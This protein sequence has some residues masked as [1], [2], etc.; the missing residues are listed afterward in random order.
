MGG[1]SLHPIHLPT[2]TTLLKKDQQNSGRWVSVS[3]PAPP[4]PCLPTMLPPSL[5]HQHLSG[6]ILRQTR[7]ADTHKFKEPASFF[8]MTGH[9]APVCLGCVGWLGG[10]R[11]C[12]GPL[13]LVSHRDGLTNIG[14][15][16]EGPDVYGTPAVWHADCSLPRG[17][18]LWCCIA[19]CHEGSMRAF[20]TPAARQ[21]SAVLRDAIQVADSGP[22][23]KPGERERVKLPQCRAIQGNTHP[24]CS[25]WEGGGGRFF[26]LS[27][28]VPGLCLT[29]WQLGG[30]RPVLLWDLTPSCCGK[31]SLLQECASFEGPAPVYPVITV[32]FGMKSGYEHIGPIKRP[33]LVQVTYHT[34]PPS[35]PLCYLTLR[36]LRGKV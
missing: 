2:T 7:Q 12:C 22:E 13:S 23:G 8:Q 18:A 19:P 3:R 16:D 25:T 10:W 36:L 24:H 29:A 21:N 15:G 34:P 26:L 32:E 14:V 5:P 9:H 17:R 20:H 6:H 31:C 1:W 27:V 35:S 30:T 4:P 33:V 28:R 11:G